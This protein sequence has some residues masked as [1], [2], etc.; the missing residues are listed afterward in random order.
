MH[1]AYSVNQLLKLPLHIES[2]KAFGDHLLVGTRQGHLLMY[3]IKFASSSSD[4]QVQLLRSNKHFSRRPII[5]L[6]VVP[7]F[8]I[9]VA[10]S[11][12]GNVTIHDMDPAVT[13]FP[14]ITSVA[15]AKGI[16]STFT[17]NVLKQ[18]SMTGDLSVVP[19]LVVAARR[20][21][22]FYYWKNRKLHEYLN[23]VVQDIPKSLAWCKET[24]CVGFKSEYSIVKLDSS[25]VINGG[26]EPGGSSVT[27]ELFPTGKSGEP[28]VTL[29]SNNRF[30]LSNDSD[31]IFVDGDC[32][33]MSPSALNWAD[34]P[35]ALAEDMPYLLAVQANGVE[36]KTNEPR[37]SIQS[38]ELP[39][40]KFICD[41]SIGDLEGR[42]AQPGLLYVASTSYIWC[43]RMISADV[44]IAQLKRDKQYELAVILAE[45]CDKN[46]SSEEKTQRITE[47][48][49]LH[50]FDLFCNSKFKDAM[51]IF[52]K[53]DVDASHVIGMLSNN[54]PA[55]RHSIDQRLYYM[56][57]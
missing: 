23:V 37:I 14:V 49:T 16:A 3:T 42:P 5:K 29:L 54:F 13:N 36:V 55:L 33:E 44:Q 41:C 11:N 21:L 15:R 50:A 7:E 2:V 38:I 45:Q 51:D 46:S 30:A 35:L 57:F 9:L 27:T 48:E 4:I 1:T 20:K 32:G 52:F 53:L 25:A 31:T 17:L 26:G 18:T 6:D 34:T 39:K 56:L 28:S 43:L 19:R 8:S 40:P 22:Q 24:I 47:I 12:D 10:L